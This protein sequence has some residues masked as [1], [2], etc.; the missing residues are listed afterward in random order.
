[1]PARRR[2]KFH[3][4]CKEQ[5]YSGGSLVHI[6][7][8]ATAGNAEAGEPMALQERSTERF[9]VNGLSV[10]PYIQSSTTATN[11]S[12]CWRKRTSFTPPATRTRLRRWHSVAD[13]GGRGTA[14]APSH[15]S[16]PRTQRVFKLTSKFGIAGMH[17][18][19]FVYSLSPR[20]TLVASADVR[21]ICNLTW[22][23][24]AQSNGDVCGLARD[25][26]MLSGNRSAP[27]DS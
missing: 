16:Q 12:S 26:T 18:T 7:G 1:M 3:V 11:R 25:A 20:A 6:K 23:R 27:E 5:I 15:G 21:G 9:M 24:I 10:A 4:R 19:V 2:R 13:A 14:G 22:P 8:L 17:P